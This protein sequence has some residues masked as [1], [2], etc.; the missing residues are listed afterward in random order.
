ML[1]KKLIKAG[2]IQFSKNTSFLKNDISKNIFSLG[3]KWMF[4]QLNDIDPKNN[5]MFD[6]LGFAPKNQKKIIRCNTSNNFPRIN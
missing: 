5:Y 6:N 2:E 4:D 3:A 1:Y